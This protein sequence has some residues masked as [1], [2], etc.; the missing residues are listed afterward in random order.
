M[1]PYSIRS[2]YKYRPN[3]LATE[4]TIKTFQIQDC[5]IMFRINIRMET[6]G[7][8]ISINPGDFDR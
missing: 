8:S 1:V 6:G 3:P 2:A 4:R 5:K 7:S